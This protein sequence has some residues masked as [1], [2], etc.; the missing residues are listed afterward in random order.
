[1]FTSRHL[2]KAEDELF[3]SR[4]FT[5]IFPTA[6]THKYLKFFGGRLPYLDKLLDAYEHAYSA[7]REKGVRR[8]RRYCEKGYCM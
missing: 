3:V 8:L 6:T 1:M 2:V 4:G 7:N 5:R